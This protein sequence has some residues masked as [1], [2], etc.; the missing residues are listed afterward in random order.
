MAIAKHDEPARTR[1]QSTE[2]AA[3]VLAC[4]SAEEPRLSLAELSARL[5]LSQSTVFRYVA[6]LQSA[7]LL[8]RDER[9]GYRLGLRVVELAGIAVNQIEV[10]KH[11]LDEMEVLRAELNLLVNLG[12]L[13][14]GDVMH[15]AASVP[16]GW[17]RWY[18]T[19]GRRAVA[20]CTTLGK[21]MLAYKPWDQVQATIE[22]YGWRPY[23]PNS[24]QDFGRLQAELEQIHRQGYAIDNEERRIGSICLGVP[25]RDYS[26]SVVAALS[27]SGT[28]ESL[29]AERQAQVLPRL[30]TVGGRISFRMGYSDQFVS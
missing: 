13:F 9:G 4:F 27:I 28:T 17:P 24:I 2:R 1:S 30:H 23:T 7:G 15:I 5:E 18:T 3:L 25:I 16:D 26:G 21:V 8:E 6:A 29:G 22:R 14:E 10:R 12:V 11:A 19:L 20:H